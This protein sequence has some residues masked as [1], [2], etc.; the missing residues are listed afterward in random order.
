MLKESVL[1]HSISDIHHEDSHS[2]CSNWAS[3]N[4]LW[5]SLS[6]VGEFLHTSAPQMM[7]HE[8]ISFQHLHFK[9]G[10]RI[11]TLGQEFDALYLV[12]SGFIKTVLFDENGYEQVLNFPMKGDVL[13]MDSMHAH[14]YASEAIA[15][16]DCDIILLPYKT[17]ISLSRSHEQLEQAIY[18]LLSR[19]LARQQQRLSMHGTSSA[20][21]RVG[22]FLL[23]LSERFYSLGYSKS[24]F[25]LRMTR[26]D[27]GSYL[28]LTLETVSRT[29]SALNELGVISVCQRQITIKDATALRNLRKL[30][31]TKL[32]T[33]L[34]ECF[35]GSHIANW[36]LAPALS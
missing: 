19:E 6:D 8:K 31:S 5:S 7:Q 35:Q 11:H 13:G 33:K 4:K 36:A 23:A 10:Q 29:L 3:P 34:T 17:L 32:K 14:E 30:P 20:E 1:M 12:N 2:A 16:S 22:K 15:M 24:T 26:N 28:G 9:A 25:N 18:S 21:A 27:I